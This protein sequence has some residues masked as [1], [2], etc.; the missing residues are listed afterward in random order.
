MRYLYIANLAHALLA[1]LLFLQKLPLTAD[2]T[3]VTLGKHIL[4]HGFHRFPGNDLASDGS[5]DGNLKQVSGD[6][7]LKPFAFYICLS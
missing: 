4:A 3:A 6:F 2:I 7:L 5:L 1:F